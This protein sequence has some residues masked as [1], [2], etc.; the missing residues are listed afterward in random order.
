[1]SQPSNHM[2]KPEPVWI[3]LGIVVAAVAVT[4]SV[5]LGERATRVFFDAMRQMIAAHENRER[6]VVFG[7]T[8]R[9]GR[10]MS[11]AIRGGVAWLKRLIVELD[12]GE[13]P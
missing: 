13:G 9:N 2:P 11:N 1:M 10:T 7:A 8:G 6:V 3:A 4:L 5:M 12:D